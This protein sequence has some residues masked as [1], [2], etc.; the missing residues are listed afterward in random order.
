M[1]SFSLSPQNQQNDRL[2]Q[3]VFQQMVADMD[4]ARARNLIG[5]NIKNYKQAEDY[6]NDPQ[7]ILKW[8]GAGH[9]TVENVSR[10]LEAFYQEYQAIINGQ[11]E[12]IWDRLIAIDYPFL[13]DGEQSFVASFI[14]S[15]GRFPVLFIACRYFR[16]TMERNSQVF[17][18]ANGIVGGH[19][20]FDLIGREYG[21]TRER[22]RQL[23]SMSVVR[24]ADAGM[25]W[26]EERWEATGFMHQPLLTEEIIHWDELRQK[27]HLDDIDSYAALAIISQMTLHHIVSLRSDGRRANTRLNVDTPWQKPDVL[28]SYDSSLNCFSFE[29]A[30]AVVGHEFSLQRISDSRMPLQD[31]VTPYFTHKHGEAEHQAVIGILRDVLPQFEG[32]ETEGDDIIFRANRLNYTEEIYRILQRKGQAMTVNDIYDEFRQLHPDDHHTESSFVRNYMLRD[33]RFE[34]I[35]SKS[36]YQLR[37][38]KRFAGALGD[39]AVHL[40]ENSAEPVKAEMLC[41]QMMEHRNAT[42]LKSCNTSIYIAV[43]ARRLMFYIDVNEKKDEAQP[44]SEVSRYYVGLFDRQYPPQFWPS[45]LTV[46]GAIRSMRR[47][48]QEYGRWPFSTGRESIE[49]TLFYT[50]RKYNKR[51]SVSDEELQRF[52]Q[53]MSDI[54]PNDYPTCDRDFQFLKRCRTLAEYCNSRHHL[55][56][57]G[58][59][60]SWYKSLQSQAAQ[61]TGFRRYHY[62]RLQAT[63]SASLQE[64]SPSSTPTDSAPQKA[65][66]LTFD[67]S[68]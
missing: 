30:L 23:G 31:I 7:L 59:L 64:F 2:L 40:L 34:A 27:E 35:G 14:K 20:R 50:L 55:P 33:E 1:N 6:L 52:Q 61:F 54:S 53:A 44:D 18:L 48:L 58:K 26:S 43:N 41:R 57:C 56:T 11:Q 37:E 62:E 5:T 46:D 45:P 66:Q 67:F 21:M 49:Q 19:R 22:V 63:I 68:E 28:F 15:E 24:A 4:D 29:N 51:K 60:L 47:F 9:V 3:H 10:L 36:T 17:A 65:V 32:V 25:V 13:T 16:H 39:L 8:H 38:W 12:G 42:T